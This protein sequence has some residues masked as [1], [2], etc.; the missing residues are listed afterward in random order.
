MTAAVVGLLLAAAVL[1][2]PAPAVRAAVQALVPAA[3][4]SPTTRHSH[5]R[6]PTDG[7]VSWASTEASPVD[8]G[9]RLAA[10]IRRGRRAVIPPA[11]LLPVLDQLAAG[12]R[13]GLPA[14]TAM[15][16]AC[17][18]AAPDVRQLVA[19][20]VAEATSAGR[21]AGPAWER[22]ARA[23]HSR[24]LALVA[25]SVGLS[26][27]LGAPLADAIGSAAAGVRASLELQRT[28]DAS[29]AGPRAT[30]GV[31]SFLPVGGIAVAGLV[32]VPPARLY[33][34]TPALLSLALGLVL[35]LVGRLVTA[36]MI[37]RVEDLR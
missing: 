29:T 1:T 11:D 12:L 10:S 8:V 26:E 23:T 14:D 17:A 32:G 5:S 36:A 21:A 27:R 7:T 30:A 22:V 25:R 18:D 16:L 20:P 35:L 31:L 3:E 19:G 2:W 9:R 13:S 24:E 37:R 28:L 4:G 34:S 33:G 15:S 6:T